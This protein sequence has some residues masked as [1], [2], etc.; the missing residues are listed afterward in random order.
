MTQEE[1]RFIAAVYEK[2]GRIQKKRKR[3]RKQ[4]LLWLGSIIL[5]PACVAAR[6][7]MF[8]LCLF[9]ALLLSLLSGLE[10]MR[11]RTE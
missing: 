3:T 11:L 10:W 5:A 6:E 7:D 2:A 9:S 4:A 1:R 8:L